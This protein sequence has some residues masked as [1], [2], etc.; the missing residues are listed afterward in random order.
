MAS[1]LSTIPAS[2]LKPITVE[3][4]ADEKY[5]SALERITSALQARESNNTQ[6]MLLAISQ[7][8]LTPGPT[9]HFGESL[10]NAAGNLSKVMQ[11]QE[12]SGLENAKMRLQLA[13]A[14]R[15]MAQRTQGVKAFNSLI[16][17]PRPTGGEAAPAGAPV[18]GSSVG[19]PTTQGVPTAEG[20]QPGAQ[21]FRRIT[22][23]D[24]LRYAAAYDPE[25][26]NL[27]KVLVEAAKF[28]SDRFKIA[29]NGT[30]FDTMAG[31]YVDLPI[32]GQK[33]EEYYIPEAFDG[34]GGKLLMTPNEYSSYRQAKEK[35]RAREWIGI[36]M[37][38]ESDDG[39]PST[40]TGGPKTTAQLEAEAAAAK[41]KAT[42]T[43]AAETGRTQAVIDAGQGATTRISHYKTMEGFAKQPGVAKLL[44]YFESPDFLAQAGTLLEEGRFGVPEIRKILTNLGAPQ[45]VIDKLRVL[46][47]L[48]AQTSIDFA[49]SYG[50]G[51][52]AVSDF[53]RKLYASLGPTIKDPVEAFLMKSKLLT[54][55]AEYEKELSS[56]LRKSKMDVDDFLESPQYQ[57]I[58][59][60]YQNKVYTVAGI[61]QPAATPTGPI[62]SADVQA[63]RDAAKQRLG[64]K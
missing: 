54:A 34:K 47:S 58:V 62:T 12:A 40:A 59:D 13:Q 35:G 19:T 50:K 42:K 38:A 10:G 55:K 48:A 20:A 7:G 52:G 32:P 45:D 30:V 18:A 4:P 41:E 63:R 21:P 15:E 39:K 16:G 56:A 5:R 44:G 36:H 27:G 11:S 57:K 53:E 6:Q 23:D 49:K 28:E 22:M 8:L 29:M 25:L 37:K 43:A 24:A 2:S 14:E 33:A 64:V 17:G 3:D 26:K 51:Q 31:K 1:P 60:S 46:D 61:K 9:G